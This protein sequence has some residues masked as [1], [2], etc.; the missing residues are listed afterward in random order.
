[1][2]KLDY[3]NQTQMRIFA[4]NILNQSFRNDAQFIGVPNGN[5]YYVVFGFD[6]FSKTNCFMHVATNGHSMAWTRDFKSILREVFLYPFQRAGLMR[7]SSLV[8]SRNR[9]SLLITERRGGI[10]EGVMRRAGI[11]GEDMILFGMLRDECP[12][13]KASEFRTTQS[14]EYLVHKS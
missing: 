12:Y 5:D 6:T 4:S 1:M 10:R 2:V 7:V 14:P 13:M 8:S 11:A 9:A 3:D